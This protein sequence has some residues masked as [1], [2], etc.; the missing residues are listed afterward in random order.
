MAGTLL[1]HGRVALI[2]GGG[3]GIGRAVCSIFA[4]EGATIIAADINES[5]AKETVQGII[6]PGK[7]FSHSVDVSTSESIVGL[8][9]NIKEI[10]LTPDILINC[11]GITRDTQML[12]MTES[13]FDDVIRVNLKGT[14]LMTQAISKLMIDQNIEA[15][16]IV[17]ISS[18]SAKIGN[19]GQ[20]NY[21]AS[22]AGVEGFTRTAA[23]ELAKYNIRC[24]TVMPGFI[25]TPMVTTVPEKVM[26]SI[27]KEIPL[28]RLGT[29]EELAE[30]CVF[31]ASKRS[32]YITG[33][34][35][36]VSGGL[37]M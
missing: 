18:V 32:S 33:C 19:F 30:T 22:K 26:E 35:I 1:L 37:F 12:K 17:N 6:D 36:Q 15:G 4:K 20:C 34:T 31:L 7:H 13:M 24:N 5:A 23:R 14:Y 11:A 10:G 2:T 3:S 8:L 21:V 27:K 9:S 29:P 25:D 28:K 16:S